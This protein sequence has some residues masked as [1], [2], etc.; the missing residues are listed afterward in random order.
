MTKGKHICVKLCVFQE[1]KIGLE[2]HIYIY[3]IYMRFIR[4][5]L[6]HVIPNYITIVLYIYKYHVH[7][8]PGSVAR[9]MLFSSLQASQRLAETGHVCFFRVQKSD[10]GT[11]VGYSL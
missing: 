4:S 9:H 3:I 10:H 7:H 11:V 2:D 1:I 8:A 5:Y 6:E